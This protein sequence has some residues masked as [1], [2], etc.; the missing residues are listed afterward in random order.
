MANIVLS[1]N[2][3]QNIKKAPKK[4]L[5]SDSGKIPKLIYNGSFWFEINGLSYLST[6]K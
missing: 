3:A 2:S 5:L 4:Q 1:V 6:P